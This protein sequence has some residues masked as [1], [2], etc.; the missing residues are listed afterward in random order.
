MEL[1]LPVS[2]SLKEKRAVLR[3]IIE[4]LRR[5]FSV[6]VAEVGYQDTWQRALVGVGL[7][8]PDSGRLDALISSIRRY[9][10]ELLEVEVCEV[11]VSYLEEE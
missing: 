6:S 4:G 7:V 9:V 11:A 10:D 8:A 3:P 1:H 5:K 2:Q